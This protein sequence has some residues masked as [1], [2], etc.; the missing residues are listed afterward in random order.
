MQA[1]DGLFAD[2]PVTVSVHHESVGRVTSRHGRNT[3]PSCFRAGDP[4][5]PVVVVQ[6][7]RINDAIGFP[8]LSRGRIRDR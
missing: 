8:R 6:A 1:K 7:E 2:N 4:P 5:V 3:V